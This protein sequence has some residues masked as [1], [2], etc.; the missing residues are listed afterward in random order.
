MVNQ[1]KV[2][3]TEPSEQLDMSVGR[4]VENK[5]DLLEESGKKAGA[6]N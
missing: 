1:N 3:A 5:I 4:G 6:L 2:W